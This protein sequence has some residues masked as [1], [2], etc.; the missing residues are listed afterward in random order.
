MSPLLQMQLIGHGFARR[1]QVR[2][3]Y[4]NQFSIVQPASLSLIA[5]T[6]THTLKDTAFFI[7]SIR[8]A[9]MV[10]VMQT[11]IYIKRD[12]KTVQNS[13]QQHLEAGIT[14]LYFIYISG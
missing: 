14:S 10:S 9:Y 5:R 4:N 2:E 7:I 12:K 6:H 13:K 1:E 11:A 8:L 3:A